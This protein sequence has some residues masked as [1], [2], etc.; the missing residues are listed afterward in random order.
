MLAH[1]LLGIGFACGISG[2][3]LLARKDARQPK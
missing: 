1:R 3:T 2:L